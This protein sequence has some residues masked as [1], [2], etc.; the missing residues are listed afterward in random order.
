LRQLLGRGADSFDDVYYLGREPLDGQDRMS[1]V[2]IAAMSSA[3][4]R[5]YFNPDD[6][7]LLGMDLRLQENSDECELRFLEWGDFNGKR[8]PSVV[9]VRSGG[10]DFATIKFAKIDFKAPNAANKN[11]P[12]PSPPKPE[13]KQ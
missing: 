13:T 1:D 8:L 12:S 7:T 3:E 4:S 5:W 10:V 6:G 11:Q 2:L 9:S